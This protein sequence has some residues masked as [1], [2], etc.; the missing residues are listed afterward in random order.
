MIE[1]LV[2]RFE[3]DFSERKVDL[4]RSTANETTTILVLRGG[5]R[6]S[7]TLNGRNEEAGEAALSSTLI[8]IERRT[9]P[10]CTDFRIMMLRSVP[11]LAIRG[12]RK[13]LY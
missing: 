13:S 3:I 6:G 9:A 10:C 12:P 7:A 5:K 4:L 1:R 11:G 8:V 2:D